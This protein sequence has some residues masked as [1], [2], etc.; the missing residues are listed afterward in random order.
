MG[1]IPFLSEFLSL[2]VPYFCNFSASE[3]YVLYIYITQDLFHHN[4]ILLGI[5]LR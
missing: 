4:H 3:L 2:V 1:H 5:L